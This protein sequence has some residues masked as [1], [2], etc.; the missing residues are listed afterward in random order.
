VIY[1][2]WMRYSF[3][4]D[5]KRFVQF[6]VRVWGVDLPFES[7]ERIALEGIQRMESFFRKLGLAV[8]LRE[9]DISDERFDEMA[10]KCA[11]CWSSG[12]NYQKLQKQVVTDILELAL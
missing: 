4:K 12:G 3:E 7:E 8:R 11:A 2:A 6:A 1:P 5:I 9:L 10:E